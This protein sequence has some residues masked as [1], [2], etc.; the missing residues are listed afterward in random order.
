MQQIN[1]FIIIRVVL[2]NE[3]QKNAGIG[4]KQVGSTVPVLYSDYTCTLLSLMQSVVL[5][6]QFCFLL[7]ILT[8]LIYY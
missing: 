8:T 7:L 3:M 1:K 5:T 6:T 2:K 4:E